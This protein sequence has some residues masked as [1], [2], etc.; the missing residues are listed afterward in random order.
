LEILDNSVRRREVQLNITEL[1]EKFTKGKL[2]E[3][4]AVSEIICAFVSQWDTVEITGNEIRVLRNTKITMCERIQTLLRE[5]Q[6]PLHFSKIFQ[7]LT[8]QGLK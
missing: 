1:L 6:K 2:V 3:N 8:E 7:L 5:H 4:G